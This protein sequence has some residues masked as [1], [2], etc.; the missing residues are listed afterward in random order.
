[1]KPTY[2]HMVRHGEVHNPD[3]I[4][5]G[6]IPGFG[7]SKKGIRQAQHTGRLL[8]SKPLSALYSSPLLRAR[9]TAREIIR[10]H[11]GLTLHLSKHLNEVC[12]PSEGSPGR[13]VD[14]RQ[15]DLYSDC[16]IGFEQ[17]RDLVARSRAFFARALKH[18]PGGHVVAVTHGDII[19]FTVLWALGAAT[20]PSNKTRLRQAGFPVAYPEHA[21]ITTL[22]FIGSSKN[23]RPDISY[24]N[25]AV[26]SI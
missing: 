18:Q 9:Q 20:I 21:S 7:L 5:Y 8:K 14:A 6:R 26:E 15:G 4:L 24:L 3:Q 12:T 22:T 13:E 10:L 23:A 17:P 1:M 11:T 2:I 16:P 19:V 25:P